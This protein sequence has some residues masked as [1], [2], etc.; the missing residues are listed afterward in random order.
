MGPD[1]NTTGGS[2]AVTHSTESVSPVKCYFPYL[3]SLPSSHPAT[4][5]HQL[6]LRLAFTI[7][8]ILL[9]Y[10]SFRFAFALS[11]QRIDMWSLP[12]IADMPSHLPLDEAYNDFY[13]L[14]YRPISIFH[15]G[16][17]WLPRIGPQAQRIPKEAEPI[18][19]HAIAPKSMSTST[20]LTLSGQALILFALPKPLVQLVS[21]GAVLRDHHNESSAPRKQRWRT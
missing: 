15:T 4:T 17:A 11:F 2:R 1:A 13:G 10:S 16:P 18:C 7:F 3:F 8:Y 12:I 14:P 20:P 21:E 6:Q 5:S 9:S 19:N